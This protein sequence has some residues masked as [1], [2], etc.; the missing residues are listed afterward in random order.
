MPSRLFPLN[1][2]SFEWSVSVFVLL[3]FVRK[4]VAAGS[5]TG[6]SALLALFGLFPF[7]DFYLL[8]LSTTFD[9]VDLDSLRRRV[10]PLPLPL[11]LLC[12]AVR[13]AEPF[14]DVEVPP[15]VDSTLFVQGVHPT[16]EHENPAAED[17]GV[18]LRAGQAPEEVVQE[19]EQDR[20]ATALVLHALRKIASP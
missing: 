13:E 8:G 10:L 11:S 19:S 18:R 5:R 3:G 1:T 12:L 7:F 17:D 6:S 14:P 16:E 15:Q 4:Q 2:R 20:T 9:V